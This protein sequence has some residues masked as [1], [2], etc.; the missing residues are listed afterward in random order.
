[1]QWVR[2]H[3]EGHELGALL[4]TL[5][6]PALPALRSL[7]LW[8]EIASG[9]HDRLLTRLSANTKARFPHIWTEIEGIAAGLCRPFKE[10]M[11]WNCR[12]EL[13]AQAPDGCTSIFDGAGFAHNEDGPP[14]LAPHAFI[15][16]TQTGWHFAYPASL[17]GNA[18]GIV[19]APQAGAYAINNIRLRTPAPSIPR[20]VLARA[21][22]DC[23]DQASLRRLLK[24]APSAG[25]HMNLI[26]KRKLTSI[27]FGG[28]RW[29]MT[30]PTTPFAHA[31]H[32]LRLDLPQTITPSSRSRLARAN[33]LL[34]AGI[35]PAKIVMDGVIMRESPNDPDGE[36]TIASF[37]LSGN[38]WEICRGKEVL[39]GGST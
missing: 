18:F 2:T 17:L 6:L 10:V 29:D 8:Q 38:D 3:A 16:E 35:S 13:S 19:N 14:S 15:I 21:A 23:P 36:N 12:G 34:Q 4:G 24:D 26:N 33:A 9:Q 1:M 22:I 39:F 32:A 25:F 11:G 30:I 7:P 27:E 37:I 20:M 28:N 5:T 31:N